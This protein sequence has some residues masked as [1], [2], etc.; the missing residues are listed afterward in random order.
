VKFCG[1]CN[2]RNTEA[3]SQN[4]N[5][6]ILILIGCFLR[7]LVQSFLKEVEGKSLA[8]IYKIFLDYFLSKIGK[9]AVLAIIFILLSC[10]Y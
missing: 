5:P 10:C 2:H 9:L 6:Q 3:F 7:I 4:L 1:K 8:L